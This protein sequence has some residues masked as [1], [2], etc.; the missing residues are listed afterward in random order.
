MKHTI[1]GL[2]IWAG[3]LSLNLTAQDF[4]KTGT[5]AGQFLKIPVGGK[6][7]GMGYAYTSIVDNATALYWNPAGIA[8]LDRVHGSV[9][10]TMW[11]AELTHNFA[12]LVV[13]VGEG[14]SF[15]ISAIALQSGSI[16]QTTIEQ[17]EG[18]GT[19]Y[20]VLD[21]AV[22][23]SYARKMTE[24]VHI[25]ATVKYVSQRI[26]NE[27]AETFA[28]DF[29]AILHTGFKDMKLGL[30]FQNVGPGLRMSGRDL[31]R[32]VD[33]DPNSTMNPYLET[34]V[35]TQEWGLP[36]SY[37]VSSSMSLIGNEGL[38]QLENSRLLLAL[39]AVHL[40][41]NPEHY[42]VGA[43]Y[44]FAGTFA[45]RGGYVFQTDEEGLTLGAGLNIPAG[46]TSF[47]FDYA[48]AVFGMLGSVQHFTLSAS[49]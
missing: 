31:I 29:G 19:F 44:E 30:S 48:Y 28:V 10:H 15:G 47:S 27:S 22:G 35:Q 3:C 11:I 36:T 8:S 17:P 37:R 39:D 42:S 7:A 34:S 46:A 43:E 21:F 16:E 14:S 5:A 2:L 1:I 45:V 24:F 40:N 33:Q 12:G 26:W 49:F 6:A 23:V 4:S 20:D 18:T 25:G 13:P 32:Q 38:V 9:S 41:D